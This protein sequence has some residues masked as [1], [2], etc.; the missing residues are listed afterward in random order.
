V[1]QDFIEIK[2]AA[3]RASDLTNQLLSFS[4]RQVLHKRN[5]DLT[6]TIEDLLNML[7][8]ILGEDIE[9]KLKLDPDLA[10]V[11]AD[12][13]QLQQVLM[14]LF[15]NSRDAMPQGGTLTLETRNL[16]PEEVQTHADLSKEFSH[17]VLI[18]F[19]DSGIGIPNEAL[20][21]IFE[22]FFTTKEVGKGTGLGL[23]VVF[24]IIEKHNGKITVESKENEGTSFFIELP[25]C[26]TDPSLKIPDTQTGSNTE[27]N[28]RA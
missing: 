9:L 4:R 12:P 3:T 23:N 7:N 26:H 28:D 15:A 13:G 20:S 19:T 11:Y 6:K 10:C 16:T 14:N 5:L 1:Y 2:K 22:P 25:V 24:N 8:R 17:Y 27:E 18:T 21:H